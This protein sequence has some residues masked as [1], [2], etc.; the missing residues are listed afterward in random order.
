MGVLL[1]CEHKVVRF[2]RL[3]LCDILYPDSRAPLCLFNRIIQ[4]IVLGEGL[5]N[6]FTIQEHSDH[7]VQ[8]YR[9]STNHDERPN[10]PPTRSPSAVRAV[11][12]KRA[13][14]SLCGGIKPQPSVDTSLSG[15]FRISSVPMSIKQQMTVGAHHMWILSYKLSH[16]KDE[17]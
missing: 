10:L 9:H 1:C 14:T 2:F 4:G 3:Q 7:V 17:N 11:T 12:L 16:S 15:S 8:F 6:V 13:G 5:S